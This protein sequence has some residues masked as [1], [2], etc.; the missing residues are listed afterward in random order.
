MRGSTEKGKEMA[1]GT[2]NGPMGTS[3][4]EASRKD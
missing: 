2:L 4:R 1:M 3:I